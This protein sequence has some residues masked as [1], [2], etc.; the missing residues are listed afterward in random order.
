MDI[1]ESKSK[2]TK[3]KQLKSKNEPNTLL[4]SDPTRDFL[5]KQKFKYED[6][7]P[8]G[9]FLKMTSVSNSIDIFL[10]TT[11]FNSNMGSF[12]DKQIEIQNT[13]ILTETDTKTL[14]EDIVA[15]HI[16]DSDPS[17]SDYQ[18]T[19]SLE[20]I[21]NKRYGPK[22][23]PT[24]LLDTIITNAKTI[25]KK[26]VKASLVIAVACGLA[27]GMIVTGLIV[28]PFAAASGFGAG[29]ASWFNATFLFLMKMGY[30]KI[31]INR[32]FVLVKNNRLLGS[33]RPRLNYSILKNIGL[34]R[35]IY[36][37]SS[38]TIAEVMAS[39]L[40]NATSLGLPGYAI[41]KVF[42]AVPMVAPK[43]MKG[44]TKTTSKIVGKMRN[45]LSESS[46]ERAS[47]VLQK[48]G[49]VTNTIDRISEEVVR[50]IQT[51]VAIDIGD[52][53]E[54]DT[55]KDVAID[56]PP[57]LDARDTK[58]DMKVASQ[59]PPQNE[60]S[61]DIS[62]IDDFIKNKKPLQTKK[63]SKS[64]A[65]LSKI[66]MIATNIGTSIAMSW[67]TGLITGKGIG[68]TAGLKICIKSTGFDKY[69]TKLGTYLTKEGIGQIF[70]LKTKLTKDP[71]NA[72]L[73]KQLVSLLLGKTIYSEQA[74]NKMTVS[75]IKEI[76][77][78]QHIDFT[79]YNLSSASK[80][81]DWQNA[82]KQHQSIMFNM[83][84]QHLVES[85][86]ENIIA[87]GAV[88]LITRSVKLGY[89]SYASVMLEAVNSQ[90]MSQ[91][92]G[93]TESEIKA[94]NT[95]STDQTFVETHLSPDIGKIHTPVTTDSKIDQEAISAIKK[96]NESLVNNPEVAKELSQT[97]APIPKPQ[98][99]PETLS[100]QISKY[101]TKFGLSETDVKGVTNLQQLQSVIESKRGTGLAPGAPTEVINI[102]PE[103]SGATD[104]AGVLP[105]GT[106]L[107]GGITGET[108][109]QQRQAIKSIRE[110][111]KALR[112][113]KEETQQIKAQEFLTKKI[114]DY[115]TRFKLSTAQIQGIKTMTD[116]QTAIR[117]QTTIATSDPTI[118]IQM[119]SI[120]D[121]QLLPPDLADV[122]KQ[123]EFN[124]LYH[125]VKK[126][127]ISNAGTWIP[128][129]GY[130]ANMVANANLGIDTI[131]IGKSTYNIALTIKKSPLF[132]TGSA[133]ES[134]PL[135]P[136]GDIPKIPDIAAI[137]AE[138]MKTT[139]INAYEVVLSTMK[140]KIQNGWDNTQF[141]TE[142]AKKIAGQE[143]AQKDV[144][145]IKSLF[146]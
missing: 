135:A 98:Y 89:K 5:E 10:S 118:P 97:E 60:I 61:A 123:T 58:R 137:V 142:L 4:D 42:S 132:S 24:K 88:D 101:A 17:L 14:D 138:N 87:F 26:I 145:Y 105:D 108:S 100:R 120:T 121:E 48:E 102:V 117:Q 13:S 11:S 112:I 44:V 80:I 30:G 46:I 66:S 141:I 21:F 72:T 95:K 8:I 35:E 115:A 81:K 54:Q 38:Y 129:Y 143:A 82:L 85:V 133:V 7:D 84:R 23:G 33:S 49:N 65:K 127:G 36:N 63:V 90:T 52:I 16:I 83:T 86:T 57:D 28:A 19:M 126:Y 1:P 144:D 130:Y 119:G 109:E 136:L 146:K 140:D 78:Q 22:T 110:E 99:D 107:K 3:K 59:P 73:G 43:L 67:V 62:M 92:A 39:E 75:E 77:L 104:I 106:I 32:F 96:I 122:L 116:L 6:P 125:A 27:Y 56:I 20:D 76:F 31:A 50:D 139:K 94:L 51:D 37:A 9:T 68:V 131:N 40:A 45:L 114:G 93:L 79:K 18:I 134:L 71:K 113:I 41:S 70:D 91:L 34:S 53:Y 47:G 64:L 103:V 55:K 15:E 128:G 74:I 124:P 111:R 2:V 69:V 12:D 29:G 25:V